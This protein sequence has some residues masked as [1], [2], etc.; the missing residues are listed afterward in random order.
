MAKNQTIFDKLGPVWVDHH[1][2][3]VRTGKLDSAVQFFVEQ[4][5]WVE[6]RQP[7]SGDWGTA[8]FLGLPYT[9]SHIQLTEDN[10]RPADLTECS[11]NQ[12]LALG[13]S[14]TAD[15][16]VRAIVIW[17]M[18][19]RLGKGYKTERANP[20]GTK[21]FIYLPEIFTFAIEM[22]GVTTFPTP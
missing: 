13:T 11:D 10:T 19:N 1:A 15:K 6:Y 5:R 14:V 3:T 2:Y 12:H 20:E 9:D 22:A 4:L 8:R 7:V 16:A 18:E 21:W 17:A